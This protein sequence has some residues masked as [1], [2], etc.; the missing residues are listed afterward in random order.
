[1]LHSLSYS[2]MKTNNIKGLRDLN[3]NKKNYLVIERKKA[4]LKEIK[5]RKTKC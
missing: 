5:I 1:M 3:Q 2:V 4:N